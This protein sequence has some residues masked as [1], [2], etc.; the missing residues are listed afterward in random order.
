MADGNTE[1]ER[2]LT[3]IR[4]ARTEGTMA[5][6]R[7]LQTEVFKFMRS[8]KNTGDVSLDD[9]RL[10]RGF[11]RDPFAQARRAAPIQRNANAES[12]HGQAPTTGYQH[13]T[14][15]QQVSPIQQP[16]RLEADRK[17]ENTTNLRPHASRFLYYKHPGTPERARPSS[18]A[19]SRS[20]SVPPRNTKNPP[21]KK[22]ITT[23]KAREVTRAQTPAAAHKKSVPTPAIFADRKRKEPETN[24]SRMEPRPVAN[25]QSLHRSQGAVSHRGRYSTYITFPISKGHAIREHINE[26][27]NEKEIAPR[28]G[29]TYEQRLNSKQAVASMINT[30]DN[31]T[32]YSELRIIENTDGM[33]TTNITMGI[34]S[35]ECWVHIEVESANNYYPQI[36]RIA[37]KLISYGTVD[38]ARAAWHSAAQYIDGDDIED[39]LAYLKSADRR[40]PIFLIGTTEDAELLRQYRENLKTWFRFLP[41]TASMFMLSPAATEELSNKVPGSYAPSPWAIRTYRSNVDLEDDHDASRHRFIGQY[42]LSTE[43]QT[44]TR[45]RLGMIASEAQVQIPRPSVLARAQR[46]IERAR[47]RALLQGTQHTREAIRDR[48]I[49][50][51]EESRVHPASNFEQFTRVEFDNFSMLCE[52]LQVDSLTEDLVLDLADLYETRPKDE[53]LARLDGMT[54]ELTTYRDQADEL[55]SLNDYYLN[56]A[57]QFEDELEQA[58]ARLRFVQKEL[59]AAGKPEEAYSF[60]QDADIFEDVSSFT[61]LEQLL[62]SLEPEGI[63]FTGDVSSMLNIDEIDSEGIAIRRTLKC[64]RCLLSYREER[65]NGNHDSSLFHYLQNPTGEFSVSPKMFAPRESESTMNQYGDERIFPVPFEVNQSGWAVMEA[66]FKLGQIGMRSPRMHIFDDLSRS[67]KIYIGYVGDHL[68][69]GST[70]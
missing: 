20:K 9:L 66:H 2:L 3:E 22:N 34:S 65:I 68:N 64:I 59:A 44:R 70:N 38:N 19:S 37:R 69:T 47:N 6:L 35:D 49:A 32:R 50:I 63:V 61:D 52:L 10:L 67:N 27:L 12:V 36:P 18:E 39:V 54:E 30:V 11:L 13:S 60:A 56:E 17:P 41:G 58:Q 26:W 24:P 25:V 53:V 14:D 15:N 31:A 40:L 28:F 55:R 16:G 42:R 4:H 45:N 57:R 62:P 29:D 23:P 1:A 7:N 21:V 46:T 8:A 48:S 5:T 33:F 43:E 51:K